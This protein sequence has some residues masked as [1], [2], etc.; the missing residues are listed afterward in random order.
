MC[1]ESARRLLKLR[2]IH[3]ITQRF[4]GFL[5]GLG[6]GRG[7]REGAG[8]MAGAGPGLRCVPFCLQIRIKIKIF[9]SV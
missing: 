2:R 4:C 6:G 9:N 7:C 1:I 8:C 3:G 5:I